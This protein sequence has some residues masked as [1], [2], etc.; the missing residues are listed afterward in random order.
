[1]MTRTGVTSVGDAM[2]TPDDLRA[3]Q[4]ARDAG[5]LSLRVY[6][7]IEYHFIDQMLAAGIRTGLGDEWVRVGAM[8]MICD[9]SISERTARLSQ[10]YIGRP[11]DFGI[12]GR[13]RRTALPG[14]AQS[15]R[16]RMATGH[17]RQRRRC[18]RHHAESLRTPATRNAAA[19]SALPPGTLHRGQRFTGPADQ[20]A[21][22]DSRC[23]FRPTSTIT[24]K[25]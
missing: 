18:H 17:A 4:D 8:K 22:R 11:N 12:H 25:R 14:R 23:R 9:G 10:P 6:C 3:Y 5:D 7:L 16:S 19:R 20:G 2:G 21:G 24:A 1:M 13:G 15:P